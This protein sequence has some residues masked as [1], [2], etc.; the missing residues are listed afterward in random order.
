[1]NLAAWM[2]IGAGIAWITQTLDTSASIGARDLIEIAI[3]GAVSIA[4]YRL[5]HRRQNA[6]KHALFLSLALGSIRAFKAIFGAYM[7]WPISTAPAETRSALIWLFAW[8]AGLAIALG[9][10]AVSILLER[11]RLRAS[12]R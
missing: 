6:W 10:A 5:L 8:N 12:V 4:G 1:M 2:L 11:R 7:T 9:V 3:G